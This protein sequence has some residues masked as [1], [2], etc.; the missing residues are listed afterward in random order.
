V[1]GVPWLIITGSGFDD[2][3]YW[4]FFTITINYNSSNRWASKTRSI[5]YWTT[6]VF[7]SAV[8]NL[9]LIYESVTSS[10][11]VVRWLTL[12]SGTLDSLTNVKW[13]NS[14]SDQPFITRGQTDERSQPRTIHLLLRIFVAAGMCLP[15]RCLAMDHSG[16]Q[17]SC[18]NIIISLHLDLPIDLFS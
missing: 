2:W 14:L 12:H 15:K 13:L 7:S 5:P 8:S 9:V 3:I 16:F 4:H 17:A 18:H 6:S 10:A 11:S 1:F